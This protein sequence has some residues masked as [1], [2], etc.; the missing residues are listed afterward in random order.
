MTHGVQRRRELGHEGDASRRV[1]GLAVAV[2]RFSRVA[3]ASVLVLIASGIWASVL[4][5][6]T[7]A[8]L[9]QTS[10]G[11][12]LLV[13][14]VLL[15]VAL[16][17]A[18]VNL[19]RTKPRLEASAARPELGEGA[20]R[21]LRRL[22][23]GEVLLVVGAIFV[24][25]IL[26]SLPP[27]PKALASIGSATKHVGPGP[28]TSV[29]THGDYKL[30]IRVVPNRA[31]QPNLFSVA[32]TKQGAPV[33]G[34]D[35]TMTFTMLDMEMGQLSYHLPETALGVY[36]WTEP[37]LVMVGHW[38][39]RFDVRPPGGAPVSVLLVDRAGG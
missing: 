14:V 15:L 7:L 21:D 16:L 19:V 23:G 5:F 17:L 25:G 30:T 35:V 37:A 10:Y 27:P 26:S 18:S 6:P 36:G 4:H 3:F 8:S 2:P 9:W 20:A 24:A 28:V 32:I 39:L 13:K 29:V 22:V 11:K 12:A 31:A 34:A 1:A 38:G 33:R